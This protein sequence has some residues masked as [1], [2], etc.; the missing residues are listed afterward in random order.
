MR[1]RGRGPAHRGHRSGAD[2]DVR[3]RRRHAAPPVS[4]RLAT[5]ARPRLATA[6]MGS[7]RRIEMRS[8]SAAWNPHK[9]SCAAVGVRAW[10]AARVSTS[11][12][13]PAPACRRRRI[14]AALRRRQVEPTGRWARQRAGVLRREYG[15]DVVEGR[16]ER[17]RPADRQ[18]PAEAAMERCRQERHRARGAG[19]SAFTRRATVPSS[20][21]TRASRLRS[22]GDG[23][24][25]GPA[26]VSGHRATPGTRR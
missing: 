7:S 20:R 17:P 19:L 10:H 1:R 12:A 6:T 22:E 18:A 13:R 2:R 9:K 26:R 25:C 4:A 3:R 15:E 14:A 21:R 24:P 16:L 23:K 8:T 5:R 11:T